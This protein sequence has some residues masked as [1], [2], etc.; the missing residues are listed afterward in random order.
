MKQYKVKL[1]WK[2][3]D[4]RN[5]GFYRGTSTLLTN[6]KNEIEAINNAIS[7]AESLPNWE[8]KRNNIDTS[9]FMDGC[10]WYGK[11]EIEEII[12]VKEMQPIELVNG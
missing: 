11:S 5:S 4:K 3:S 12:S 2:I 10:R 9:I 6:A 7:F 8:L 1:N